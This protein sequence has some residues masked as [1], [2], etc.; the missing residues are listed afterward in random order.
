M[1]GLTGGLVKPAHIC[2]LFFTELVT[3]FDPSDGSKAKQVS[4]QRLS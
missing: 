1:L 2:I 3:P 4:F